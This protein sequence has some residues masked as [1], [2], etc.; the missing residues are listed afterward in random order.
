M[1][2]TSGAFDDLAAN[3]VDNLIHPFTDLV[4]HRTLGPT[5]IVRGEG[6]RVYDAD[7]NEYIEGVS[8]IWSASLGFSEQRLVDAAVAQLQALP[9]YHAVAHRS[10]PPVIEL[11]TRLT[12]LAPHD[13]AKV[14]FTGSGSEANDALCRVIWYVNNAQG[15]PEKKKVFAHDRGYH[16]A[17]VWT[18]GLTGLSSSHQG[19]EG[20]APLPGIVHVASPDAHQVAEP[21]ETPDEFAIRL[22]DAVERRI[23]AEGPETVAAFFAEPVL[24]AA[25]VVIP[26]PAY[27]PL[28]GAMLDCHDVLLVADEVITGFGRTGR[29]WGSEAVGLAPAACTFAKAISGGFAPIAAVTLGPQLAEPLVE[30]SGA[31]GGFNLGFTFGG[32]PV[33]AAVANAAIDLTLQRDLPRRAAELGRALSVG[34]RDLMDISIVQEARSVGLLGA[35]D[36]APRR[37]TDPEIADARRLV[38]AVASAAEAEGLF[39]RAAG[40]AVAVCPPL[41]ITADD[42]EELLA[43]L[44]RALR[45]VAAGAHSQGSRDDDLAGR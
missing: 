44:G 3:D 42:L 19:F 33:S 2:A 8:G 13:A 28:L 11:A 32:H 27:Y 18:A 23:L 5:I 38:A 22:V 37:A 24:G 14:L 45:S 39:V 4:A 9:N 36:L 10:S 12:E 29:L 31:L 34:L 20:P 6:V 7:D 30:Q 40:T 17:T 41:V 35:L 43:R 26:P 21:G 16:G 15:R 1:S 25:G